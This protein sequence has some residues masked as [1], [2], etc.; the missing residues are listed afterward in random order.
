MK[1]AYNRGNTVLNI[2]TAMGVYI[3]IY[4]CAQLLCQEYV[5]VYIYILWEAVAIE[6]CS[7]L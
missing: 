3:Y 6:N 2:L 1:G 7:D 4:I 5:C